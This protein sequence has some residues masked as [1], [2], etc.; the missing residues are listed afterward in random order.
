MLGG[1][2]FY[3][4]GRGSPA[5]LFESG[6]AGTLLGWARVQPLVAEFTRAC[7]Y[8]RA[9]LGWSEAAQRKPTLDSILS[10]LHQVRQQARLF[11]PFI[12]VGHSF[13]CLLA[14]A[15]AA[16]HPSDIAGLVLVDPAGVETWSNCNDADRRRLAIGARLSRRGALLA[17]V[18][19][20]RVTLDLLASGSRA[21]P[22]LI[23]KAAAGKG[24]STLTRLIGEVQQLP[25][26][27]TPRIRSHWS[28]PK[29]FTAMANYLECLPDAAATVSALQLPREIPLTIL[30]ASTATRSER[31][32][33]ELWAQASNLGKHLIVP[34]SNH[35]IQIKHPEA[36]VNAIREMMAA[37]VN[38]ATMG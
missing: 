2:H 20:V 18:G 37:T 33:R 10:D 21:L 29:S 34:D 25:P 5:V 19:I 4:D 9:G 3:E 22:K 8:D 17:R 36:V 11:E 30:S 6:I 14:L 13:G 31:G 15:Y 38:P 7:S 1:L 26:E 35:W 32:E 24:Q 27:C 12:L 16:R 23:S 28:N